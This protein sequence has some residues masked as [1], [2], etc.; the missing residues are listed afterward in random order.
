MGIRHVYVGGDSSTGTEVDIQQDNWMVEERLN[1]RSKF[2]LTIVNNNGANIDPLIEIYLYDDTTKLWGGIIMEV[3]DY[4]PGLHTNLFYTCACQDFSELVSRPVISKDYN[5]TNQSIGDVVSNL[6]TSYFSTYGVKL[7]N[8]IAETKLNKATFVYKRGD[9]CLDW[10]K[11]L[12]N[13]V[14]YIDCDKKLHFHSVGYL[15][16]T[17]QLANE[18]NFRK[19]RSAR[20]YRNVQYVKGRKRIL[21]TE[22]VNKSVTPAPDGTSREFFTKYGIAKEP[23]IQVNRGSGWVTQTVGLKGL[24]T[25]KQFYWNYGDTQ[26]THDENETVLSD[27]TDEIRVTYYGLI[28]LIVAYSNASEVAAHGEIHHYVYNDDVE[29]SS[30]ALNYAAKLIEKYANDADTV[31]FTLQ[32]KTYDI[33][34]QFPIVKSSPWNINETYLVENIKWKPRG[35]NEID[36]TYTCPDGAALGGWEDFFKQLIQPD[37]VDIE[38]EEIVI[39]L[40]DITETHGQDGSYGITYLTP[41]YPSNSQN[42]GLALFPGT[43]SSTETIN[44]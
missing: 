5:T 2:N 26:L 9:L 40:H 42:P 27:S 37:K 29:D 23:T 38:E 11:D 14:W 30:D 16:T 12:G 13:F 28:P 15:T 8:I 4:R 18:N 6:I 19:N 21:D 24:V 17:T 7:G 1:Y 43:I 34:Y 39:V 36:Y 33:G 31:N 41:L 44:D 25:D 10:L 32:N 22:Q 20:N 3:N 35:V